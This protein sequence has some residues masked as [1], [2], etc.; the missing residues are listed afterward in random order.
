MQYKKKLVSVHTPFQRI[1]VYD[2]I[3]ERFNSVPEF[4]QSLSNDGSYQSTYPQFFRPDRIIFL[5]GVMQSRSLGEHAYH[6]ALVHPALF[7]H[8]N[9]KRAAIIGG[10]EGATLREVLKHNTIQKAIMIDIDEQMVSLSRQYLPEWSDCSDLIG[11]A[12]WCGDDPRAEVRYEDG[13]AYFID[14][15]G[16][17]K[18]EDELFDTIIVDALDPQDEVEFCD[19]LYNNGQF[20]GSLFHGLSDNGALVIQVGESPHPSDP[21]ELMGR[22]KN[23]AIL[24]QHL[25]D[26]GFESLHIYGEDHSGFTG[27]WNYLVAFKSHSQ[28]RNWFRNEAEINLDIHKR[29]RKTHSGEPPLV[30]FDSATMVLY[31][32][33]SKPFQTAY[34]KSDP[35]PA[36]CNELGLNPIIPNVRGS[37][38]DVKDSTLGK[39]AGRGIF[40]K[41]DILSGSYIAAE[42]SPQ[43]LHFPP[44]TFDLIETFVENDESDLECF[45]Y[46]MHGY[47]FQMRHRGA[48]EVYVDGSILTFMNHGCNGTHN[49]GETIGNWTESSASLESMPQELDG[50]A[51]SNDYL[52][53]PAFERHIRYH[54]LLDQA[55]RDIKT[56]EEL[57]VNYLGYIGDPKDWEYDI[58]HLLSQCYDGGLGDVS[59]Y[60]DDSS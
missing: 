32:I 43:A 14:R 25:T 42:L 28:R 45:S 34:C 55:R 15:Y 52:F 26:L 57:M 35:T 49:V 22:H 54:V 12:K 18:Q 24:I 51:R 60:E 17:D 33:P 50:T 46:Y 3:Q 56:G 47:G 23:R 13:L 19:A 1:D 36:A 41:S 20:L 16:E 37:L 39:Q 4:K 53:N 8:P 44:P 27:P 7:A 9:P 6:E 2:V 48:R 21:P 11:S 59:E 58:K 5:D 10:G 29:I 38:L 31:Q 30:Y 40:S